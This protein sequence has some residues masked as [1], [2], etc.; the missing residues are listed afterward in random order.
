MN[1]TDLLKWLDIQKYVFYAIQCYRY[2]YLFESLLKGDFDGFSWHTISFG[3]WKLCQYFSTLLVSFFYVP[4]FEE[5]AEI[6]W[7]GLVC[8]SVCYACTRSITVR[9]IIFNLVCG[10][11]MKIKKTNIFFL[12]NRT[13][14]AELLPFSFSFIFTTACE[15]HIPRTASARVVK[16]ISQIVSKM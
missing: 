3:N 13:C 14:L 12:V 4:N 1:E 16:F 8:P 7:F 2:M 9:D 10:M 11:N 6:Y 15:Q 5:V